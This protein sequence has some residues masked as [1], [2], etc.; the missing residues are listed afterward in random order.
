MSH[1]L[2]EALSRSYASESKD[3]E[4][5]KAFA[6]EAEEE[7]YTQLAKLFRAVS[8][9]KA[10]HARRYLLS[11]RGKI[12]KTRENLENARQS[13]DQTVREYPERIKQAEASGIRQVKEAFSHA[14]DVNKEYADMFSEAMADLLVDREAVYCVCQI[15]GHISIGSAPRNCP[16]CYAVQKKFKRIQ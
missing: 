12:G 9:G 6:L 10:I 4:R 1:Q 14:R 5:R 13:E 16:I 11:M 3:S 15:C 7:G 2:R 8:I